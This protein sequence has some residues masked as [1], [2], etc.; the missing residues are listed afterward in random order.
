MSSAYFD[1][2][3]YIYR[4]ELSDLYDICSRIFKQ[5][6]STKENHIPYTAF[7]SLIYYQSSHPPHQYDQ[8]ISQERE[9]QYQQYPSYEPDLD[10]V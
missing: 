10:W 4:I 6:N 3:M 7:C 5:Y 8:E 2:W 9:Q 1:Y